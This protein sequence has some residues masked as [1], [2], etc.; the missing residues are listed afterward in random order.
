MATT[1][2]GR[3]TYQNVLDDILFDAG[4]VDKLSSVPKEEYKRWILEAERDICD[5]FEVRDQIDL[6]LTLGQEYYL[7]ADTIDQAGTG[8]ISSSG[9]TITGV[10]TLFTTELLVNSTIEADSE[11]R[12]ITAIASA[13]SATIDTAFSIALS[14]D[15][16]TVTPKSTEIPTETKY[17]YHSDREEGG[18]RLNV[19]VVDIRTLLNLR[20]QDVVPQ[21]YNNLSIP[22][23]VAVKI[24]GSNKYLTVYPSPDADKTITL[25]RVLRVNPRFHKD[26]AMTS[27]IQLNIEYESA[28]RCYVLRNIHRHLKDEKG[29]SKYLGYYRDEL[30]SLASALP[31]QV[32]ATFDYR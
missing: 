24:V 6:R 12:T 1:T 7:F 21:N 8:T 27:L 10:G 23:C 22:Y 26:D 32:K 13:T 15:T 14:A 2:Y 20:E 16:F 28:I 29:E 25:Y 4:E 9:T 11:T 5:K 30:S 3:S 19:E 18:Y 17:I 31:N